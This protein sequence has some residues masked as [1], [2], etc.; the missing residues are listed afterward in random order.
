MNW[1]HH[2][3]HLGVYFWRPTVWWNP[4][5]GVGPEERAWLEEK[6]PGWND[7]FGKYWDEMGKNVRDGPRRS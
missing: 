2:A 5:A 6:Y 3:Y 1:V 7:S 4:V